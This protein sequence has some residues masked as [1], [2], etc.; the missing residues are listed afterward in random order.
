M[1]DLYEVSVIVKQDGYPDEH[2]TRN[3]TDYRQAV[4]YYEKLKGGK[5]IVTL[6][7]VLKHWWVSD[8][9]K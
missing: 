8:M 7:K 5:N 9:E 3:Y 1:D 2:Y 4:E 6:S